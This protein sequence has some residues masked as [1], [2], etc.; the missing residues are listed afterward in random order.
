ME[1]IGSECIFERTDSF[2]IK[3]NN[4]K[5]HCGSL[6]ADHKTGLLFLGR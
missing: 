5:W 6:R 4:N 3:K 1:V 2:V